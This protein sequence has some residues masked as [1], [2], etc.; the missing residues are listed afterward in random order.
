MTIGID[1]LKSSR[2]RFGTFGGVFTPAILT[3]LGVIMFMRANFVVGEAGILGA[4]FILIIAKSITLTT[5]LS[6]AA[7]STNMQVR[8]G[9]SY[10][11][12]S[13]VLGPEYGGAIGIALFFALA[14]SVPFYILGFTEALISSYPV[15]APHFLKV[16]LC[17]AA[18]LFGVAYYGAGLAIKT[19]FVIM[20]F[21]G[22]AVIAFLGGAARIFSIDTFYSN[23]FPVYTPVNQ[24]EPGAHLYSFWIIFAIYFPAV[25]GIDA[26]VNMSGDLKEPGKSIPRGTMAAVGVGFIIYFAQIILGGGAYTRHDLVSRPY[27]LLRDNALFGWGFLV[28]FGVI[29]ATLSSALSSYL[30]APRVLQAVSRDRILGLIRYFGKGSHGADEPRRALVL[31]LIITLVVLLW[32]GNETG[33]ISLN[34][35]AAVIT[36]FFLYSYGMINLAAFIEDFSDNPSFRPKFRLF[37][38]VT[39]LIG[40]IGCLVVSFMISWFAAATAILL[41]A[42]L[43]WQLKRRH[44]RSTFGDARRGFVY[45]AVRKNLLR[46]EKFHV[47]PKTWRPTVLV[48]SGNPKT[49]EVLVTF[50]IWLEGGRGIA[51]LA[52]V[53]VGDFNELASRRSAALRQ[54]TKYCQEKD[55]EAFPV[56]VIAESMDEGISMLLQSTFV[57]PIHPNMVI[58]GWPDDS[59]HIGSFLQHLRNAKALGMSLV[60]IDSDTLPAPFNPKRIDVWWRGRSNGPLMVM[61]AYLIS[62]NWEWADTDIRLLRVIENEAGYDSAVTALEEVVNSARVSASVKVI[63]SEES[64]SFNLWENSCDAACVIMGFEIPDS[65]NEVKWHEGL[66]VLLDK[67]PTVIMVNSTEPEDLLE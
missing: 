47:S 3:I 13:R 57:G 21:L 26:G 19:Q 7:I 56:A 32:A 51:F 49:H 20:T 16:T 29:A 42:L 62:Q 54:L 25:T 11:L 65:G 37:H 27:E 63:I 17:T 61:L 66:E 9:G 45:N 1:S 30:G 5:S 60:L 41:I 40:S 8:G 12:I 18:I 14:L 4:V 43:V 31:T 38:W 10:Y 23:L 33:G 22:L 55:I 59:D 48:L 67:M 24:T 39:A 36:M 58:F 53:L 15:L 34:I 46:L 44:L 64:F 52:N 50:S 6:I 35:V 28:T 2:N